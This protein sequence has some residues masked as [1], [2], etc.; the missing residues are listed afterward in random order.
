MCLL[1]KVFCQRRCAAKGYRIGLDVLIGLLTF[2]RLHIHIAACA[3]APDRRFRHNGCKSGHQ[4]FLRLLPPRICSGSLLSPAPLLRVFFLRFAG[5]FCAGHGLRAMLLYTIMRVSRF[6]RWIV[7]RSVFS[8]HH[9]VRFAHRTASRISSLSLLPHSFTTWLRSLTCRC[10]RTPAVF[11]PTFHFCVLR[12]G[13]VSVA[14]G[15]FLSPAAGYMLRSYG[16]SL[17]Y[18]RLLFYGWNVATWVYCSLLASSFVPF[19][20]LPRLSFLR[21]STHLTPGYAAT[22]CTSCSFVFCASDLILQYA[23]CR[24][25]FS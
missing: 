9:L 3:C 10:M 15:F 18:A 6:L 21:T 1:D 11:T 13:S 12:V 17:L 19:L 24:T 25:V 2:G 7:C 14:T 20:A 4:R 23:I 16:V 8:S 22:F 5:S